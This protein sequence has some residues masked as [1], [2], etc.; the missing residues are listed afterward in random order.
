MLFEYSYLESPLG[1]LLLAGKANVLHYLGLPNGKMKLSAQ[2]DWQHMQSAF[3][4]AKQQLNAYFKGG[5]KEFDLAIAP[6]GT[7]FQMQVLSALQDIPYGQ[8]RSYKDIAHAIGKPSSMRAVG[9]ANG[10]N[11]LPLIIPCHRVIGA[12]GSLTGFGGGM[13]AKAFLLRLEGAIS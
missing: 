5:L 9:A 12:D 4:E 7:P 2:K 11:P 13:D 3:E 8:V 6:Q 1:P 10:R